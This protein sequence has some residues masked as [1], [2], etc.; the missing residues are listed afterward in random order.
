[1]FP[2]G[3]WSGEASFRPPHTPNLRFSAPPLERGL[4]GLGN[5]E[6]KM[7]RAKRRPLAALP[8]PCSSVPSP[9][10]KA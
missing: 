2:W 9:H 1:V 6:V 5:G 7:G 4:W 3:A 10:A 8:S